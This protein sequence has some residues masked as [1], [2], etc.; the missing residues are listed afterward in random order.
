MGELS[1]DKILSTIL[2]NNLFTLL[3]QISIKNSRPLLKLFMNRNEIF[4]LQP[5]T[6]L[7]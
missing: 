4:Y 2:P 3:Y 6:H 7:K 1:T 5:R